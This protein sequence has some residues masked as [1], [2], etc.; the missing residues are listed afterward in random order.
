M[1]RQQGPYWWQRFT[2][3]LSPF[4]VVVGSVGTVAAIVTILVAFG[5]IGQY[6]PAGP[7][8]ST[9]I[10]GPTSAAVEASPALP[11]SD[12]QLNPSPK[13]VATPSPTPPPASEPYTADW[14]DGLGGWASTSDWRALDGRL[15]SDGTNNKSVA[16]P[17]WIP[18][19]PDYTVTARIELIRSEACFSF[20]LYARIVSGSDGYMLSIGNTTPR[21]GDFCGD[22]YLLLWDGRDVVK[23]VQFTPGTA[24]H[25]YEL[26]VEGD[27]VTVR[28]DGSVKMS[29]RD[30]LNAGPGQPGVFS[31]GS[32][33]S[34]ETFQAAYP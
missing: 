16:T 31:I 33:V 1:S 15:V 14:S 22:P 29:I 7:S 34:V 23:S 27:M 2:E 28:I 6:H 9:S 8:P 5:F 11:T 3:R 30:T 20:G 12:Q 13:G 26:T 21:G 24:P 32:Q 4:E 10:P 19:T 25:D 18:A 17:D